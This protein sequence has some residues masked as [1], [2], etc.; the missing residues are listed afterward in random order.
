MD[1][2][3]ERRHKPFKGLLPL[4]RNMSR[5]HH[6]KLEMEHPLRSVFHLLEPWKLH[7]ASPTVKPTLGV[8]RPTMRER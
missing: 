6:L 8:K 5:V 7:L 3:L 4:Q 2:S 1:H